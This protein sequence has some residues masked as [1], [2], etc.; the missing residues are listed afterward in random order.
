M[1]S[2]TA[3]FLSKEKDFLTNVALFGLHNRVNYHSWECCVTF[4]Y[5]T[6]VVCEGIVYPFTSTVQCLNCRK[7]AHR[8]CCMKSGKYTCGCFGSKFCSSRSTQITSATYTNTPG[9]ITMEETGVGKSWSGIFQ[10]LSEDFPYGELSAHVT[11][12]AD[13]QKNVN[14]LEALCMSL[15]CDPSTFVGK[16]QLICCSIFMNLRFSKFE[17][18]CFHCR[19]CLDTISSAVVQELEKRYSI[20]ADIMNVVSAVDK[21]VM[22]SCSCKL[23]RRI[24]SACRLVTR[25]IDRKLMKIACNDDKYP[26][27]LVYGRK[28]EHHEKQYV[29]SLTTEVSALRKCMLLSDLLHRIANNSFEGEIE[30][31][32]VATMNCIH[33]M[34]ADKL[35]PIVVQVIEETLHGDLGINWHAECKYMISMCSER[36]LSGD[37]G[38]SLATVMQALKVVLRPG[39]D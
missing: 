32:S 22:S 28:I 17:D 11:E 16:M 38:Y 23:Y 21:Y 10:D 37:E 14:R 30:V 35:L 12:F 19:Y 39:N 36:F 15:L 13:V 34:D 24:M 1:S 9:L 2:A 33:R 5:S 7:R 31:D 29:M 4:F 20:D 26:D 3:F 8:S 18:L 6:C 25:S 27:N